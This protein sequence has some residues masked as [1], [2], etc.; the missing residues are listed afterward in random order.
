MIVKFEKDYL[1]ELYK[2]GKCDKKHSFQ[3]DIIS[4]YRR[5]IEYLK[6]ADRPEDLFLLPS[7]HYEALKGNKVGISSIRVN[8]RYRLEFTISKHKTE[9]IVYICNILESSNHYK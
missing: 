6:I 2:T 9:T 7:L 3:P 8:D 4:R 1:L 5:R